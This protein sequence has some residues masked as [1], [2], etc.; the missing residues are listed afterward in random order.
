[1]FGGPPNTLHLG[2]Y[3]AWGSSNW[4]IIMTGNVQVSNKHLTMGRDMV[5]PEELTEDTIQPFKM[6][7]SAIHNELDDAKQAR[8]EPESTDTRKGTPRSLAVMQLSH[9]GR[10]SCNFIGGRRLNEPPLAP[11]PLRVTGNKGGL[12]SNLLFKS[13]FQTPKEMTL[14]DIDDAVQSFVRGAT[15]A[16]KSGFDGVQLH[17]AHGCTSSIRFS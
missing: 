2:L 13:L 16:W 17:V 3:K 1:M 7:A 5:V 15:L 10:Q 8:I 12:L 11:S 4:G 9:A 14:D 6:L